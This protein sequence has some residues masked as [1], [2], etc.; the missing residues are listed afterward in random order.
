MEVREVDFVSQTITNTN[1][2]IN[3]DVPPSLRNR[4]I[5]IIILPAEDKV[6]TVSKPQKNKRP[7][8]FLKDKVP[9]L[10]DSF[11]DPLPEEDLQAW[12]GKYSWGI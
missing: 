12:E 9:E 11:F 1:A 2:S 7:L 3:I 6:E 8:G 4:K 10:P 5:Q